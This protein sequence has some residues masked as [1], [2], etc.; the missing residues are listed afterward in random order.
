MTDDPPASTARPG[1]PGLGVGQLLHFTSLALLLALTWIAWKY[2]GKPCPVAFWV[3]IAVPVIHQVFVWLAWRLELRDST[4]GRTVG[5]QAYL[6]IFFVLLAAR[7]VSLLV[8]AWMDAGSLGL[9]MLPRIVITTVCGLVS[10][11]LG[12]SLK[13]YFGF[14]RAAGAD[15]FDPRYRE[16]PLVKEGIFRFT[17]NGMYIYGFLALWAIAIGFDSMAALIVTAFSHCYIWVH[18]YATEKPDMDYLYSSR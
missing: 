10:M 15:H 9:P 6:V 4:T 5:F 18:F 11:Y 16:M 1:A 13:R 3:A 7:P 8:V 2:A 14:A 12:Y 17:S